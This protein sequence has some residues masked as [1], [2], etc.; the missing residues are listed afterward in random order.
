M[1]GAYEYRNRTAIGICHDSDT[2]VTHHLIKERKDFTTK[3]FV[4]K[5]RHHKYHQ[6]PGIC[7]IFTS[8]L[9]GIWGRQRNGRHESATAPRGTAQSYTHVPVRHAAAARVV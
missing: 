9:W 7:E 8:K 2:S 4:A 5:K 1:M 3:T 6:S